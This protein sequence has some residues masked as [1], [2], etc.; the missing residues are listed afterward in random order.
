MGLHT[1]ENEIL[2][3]TVDNHGAEIKSLIR[4][5]DNKELMWQA[6]SKYWGRTAP[7]LFP[8]VGNYYQ[9]KSIYNGKTYE[10]GQH[11]FARDM[12]FSLVKSDE[13]SLVF[14]LKSDATSLEKYP[15]DFVL[16]ISYTLI[17]NQLKVRWQVKNPNSTTMYF[18]IGGHPAFNCDLDTYTLRFENM[19]NPVLEIKSKV[20][21][22][23][24]TGC[25]SDN[26]DVYKLDNGKLNLSDE[27]FS[28]DALIIEDNQ[29]DAVT[30]VD[31]VGEDVLTVI[32]DCPLF[33][34]WSPVGKHAPFLCIEP[35]YG[36][37][38]RVG[39]NQQLEERE[40]GNELAPGQEFDE[41]YSIVV[42]D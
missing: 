42:A 35:W 23:D 27:L 26:V 31:E 37:C 2:R 36:R 14:E 12:D 5:D 24:G 28:K 1:I 40:Y 9:K 4:I 8:L 20:I 33:G 16:S 34:V 17:E 39:F 6:D 19:F 22:D 41:S 21:A 11:G 18:S 13:E 30:L 25:L 32:M 15:F 10:M 38:D 7:V 3:L 29:A